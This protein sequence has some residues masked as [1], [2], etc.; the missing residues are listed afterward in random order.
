MMRKALLT[1]LYAGVLLSAGAL[2]IEAS[3]FAT[4]PPGTNASGPDSITHGA[5]SIWVSYDGGTNSD[6]SNPNTFSTIVRYSPTGAEQNIYKIQGDVDGLKYNPF[7]G[8][9][10]ALQNQD[11]NSHLTLIDP[12]SG[13]LTSVSYAVTSPTQGYDDVVFTKNGTYLSE[14]NPSGPSDVTLVK[15]VPNTSP[16]QVT[17]LLTSGSPGLNVNTKKTGFVPAQPVNTDSLKLAP[18]GTLYQTTGANRD[19][20]GIYDPATGALKYLTLTANGKAVSGM[21]DT[22]FITSGSGTLYA[23]ATSAGTGGLGEVDKFNISLPTGTL[24]A[25]IG[26]LEEI[27]IVDQ[28]TGNLTP[29]LSDLEGIHGLDFVPTVVPE[30][31]TIVTGAI[32]LIGGLLIA[33]RRRQKAVA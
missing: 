8:Q 4:P 10:W 23:T 26:S 2:K 30:T 32:A 16:I 18:N 14:T 19:T 27:A 1:L 29:F 6:G 22:L 20:I 21:D 12:V 25:S 31:S 33:V 9:V 24:I 15:I 7:T 5:G 3:V 17:P 11:A 13:T 28:S